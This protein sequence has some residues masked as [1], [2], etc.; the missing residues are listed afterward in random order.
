MKTIGGILAGGRGR[1]MEGID[2]PFAALARRPLIAHVIDRLAGQIDAIVLNANSAPERFEAFGLDVVA[3]SIEGFRGPLAGIHALMQAA[4]ARGASH[5]LVVPADTPFLPRDLLSRL[6]AANPDETVARIACSNER[7][8][9]V[10]AL[11]PAALAGHLGD[12]LAATDD[13]SMAAYFRQIRVAEADF[14]DPDGPDPF[15]NIND[16]ADLARAEQLLGS[17]GGVNR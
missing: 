1:R 2:K 3:D 11:W 9:S 7:R 8:H 10:V 13:L 15:F 12:Y 17:S 6:K 5:V 16:S 4:A 14:T